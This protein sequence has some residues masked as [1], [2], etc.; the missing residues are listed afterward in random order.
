M[1]C[2]YCKWW[3]E[4]KPPPHTHTLPP[5]ILKQ[6]TA[7][8]LLHGVAPWQKAVIY[9]D[10]ASKPISLDPLTVILECAVMLSVFNIEREGV[11]ERERDGSVHVTS[12]RKCRNRFF[13]E[14]TGFLF[15][16][17]GCESPVGLS[18]E[19]ATEAICQSTSA[20]SPCFML[21]L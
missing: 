5:H 8:S 20:H 9:H 11:S 13:P 19:L 2:S 3:N 10:Y 4:W 17:S 1:F 18:S 15:P 7:H 21:D 16:P 14:K 6:E 12:C